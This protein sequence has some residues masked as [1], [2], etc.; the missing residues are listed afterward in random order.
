MNNER[1]HDEE[2]A[3]EVAALEAEAEVAEATESVD[4][5]AIDDELAAVSAELDGLLDETSEPAGDVAP[6]G[7]EPEPEADDAPVISVS[8]PDPAVLPELPPL[9]VTAPIPPAPPVPPVPTPAPAVPAP[10]SAADRPDITLQVPDPRRVTDYLST[11][12]SGLTER[13][14]F[15]IIAGVALLLDGLL[16]FGEPPSSVVVL[17]SALGLGI[18]VY[19]DDRKL[20]WSF[21]VALAAGLS[22]VLTHSSFTLFNLGAGILFYRIARHGKPLARTVMLFVGAPLASMFMSSMVETAYGSLAT[23]KVF[24]SVFQSGSDEVLMLLSLVVFGGA[25][26]MGN[27][28]RKRDEVGA[29]LEVA[30]VERD[31]ATATAAAAVVERDAAAEIARLQERQ[32]ALAH[33]VHDVVGHSLAVVLAQAESTAFIPDDDVPALRTAIGNIEGA[34]RTALKEVRQVLAG[35]GDS[36]EPETVGDALDL[37]DSARSSGYEVAYAEHGAPVELST[38]VA[39]VAYRVLQELLTNAIKHGTREEPIQ[40][41]RTFLDDQLVIQVVNRFDPKATPASGARS[42]HEGIR[43]RLLRTGGRLD[44]ARTNDTPGVHRF[45]ATATIRL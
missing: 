17:L 14:W 7:P 16:S 21:A 3:E 4:E 44:L 1:I 29:A 5:T 13:T 23:A 38:G 26:L 12:V 36:D 40:V 2:I 30:E 24:H 37:I 43:H 19:L 33:D 39:T 10:V 35:T 20:L 42:G 22:Q 31:T 6:A 18:L 27:S 32:A 41:S 25:W 11:N 8:Q 45:V 9:R 15:A 34:A 28:A